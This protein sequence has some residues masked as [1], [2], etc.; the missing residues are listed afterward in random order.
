MHAALHVASPG[1]LESVSEVV[2]ASD[3][4]KSLFEHLNFGMGPKV[5]GRSVVT[6]RA[7]IDGLLPYLEYLSE[8]DIKILW[9]ACN[10]NSWFEWRRQHLDSRANTESIRFVDDTA[11]LDE[12]DCELNRDRPLLRMDDWGEMFLETGVSV[13]HLM[14]LVEDWVLDRD[15]DRA[16][17]M[18]AELVTRFGNRRH[19]ALL[20]QHKLAES[21]FGKQVIQNVNFAIRLRSL[22]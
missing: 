19:V 13:D 7:Q 4:P 11:A 12:L 14:K 3:D 8:I 1:L 15:Q 9:E 6:R 2:A 17:S 21:Q 18:A 5:D 10:Q 16:L 22:E 20:T